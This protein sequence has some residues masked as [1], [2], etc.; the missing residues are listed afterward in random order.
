MALEAFSGAVMN[1]ETYLKK[2]HDTNFVWG[3]AD[4]VLFT[5]GWI[6]EATGQD[7]LAG[8]PKWT[9]KMQALRLLVRMG[10]LELAVIRALGPRRS[11]GFADGDV[12]Y[13]QDP[14]HC[15]GIVVGANVAVLATSGL[16]ALSIQDAKHIWSIKHV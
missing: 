1:L 11:S 2:Y 10:G 6:K 12:A 14:I 8:I 4:C 3:Q 13:M 7:P 16:D 15:M 5:A 9:S